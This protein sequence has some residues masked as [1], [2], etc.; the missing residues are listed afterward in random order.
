MRACILYDLGIYLQTQEIVTKSPMEASG[1][2]AVHSLA[3][4]ARVVGGS[5]TV[6]DAVTSH[7]GTALQ[8]LHLY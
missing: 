6:I 7:H 3:K 2:A 5:H 8:A 4:N 1:C